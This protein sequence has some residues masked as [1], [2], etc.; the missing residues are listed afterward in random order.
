V[1]FEIISSGFWF[2]CSSY[3]LAGTMCVFAGIFARTIHNGF[4]QKPDD[5]QGES[6]I[7]RLSVVRICG[8]VLCFSQSK[9]AAIYFEPG[10]P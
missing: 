3:V 8:L 4:H 1:I 6:K 10:A 7:N 9:R 2:I 5:T